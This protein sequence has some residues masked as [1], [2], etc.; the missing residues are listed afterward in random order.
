MPSSK[1]IDLTLGSS[2]TTYAAPANGWFTCVKR[3]ASAGQYLYLRTLNSNVGI[4]TSISNVNEYGVVTIPIS[5]GDKCIVVY[6]ATGQGDA[7]RF[8][9]VYAQ[10]EQ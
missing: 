4:Q 9:F 6:T 7:E 8:R 5:K 3:A 1:Y 10:G 2:G